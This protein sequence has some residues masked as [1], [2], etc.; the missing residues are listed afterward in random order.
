MIYAVVVLS[1]TVVALTAAL[2]GN[3]YR[4]KQARHAIHRATARVQDV[5]NNVDKVVAEIANEAAQVVTEAQGK[6]AEASAIA[7]KA[8]AVVEGLTGAPL[9]DAVNGAIPPEGGADGV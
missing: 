4:I 7:V 2:V 3:L 6:H 9:A 8:G 1:I 5:R